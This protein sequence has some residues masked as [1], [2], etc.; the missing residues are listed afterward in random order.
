MDVQFLSLRTQCPR[1]YA[2]PVQFLEC[3]ALGS[4]GTS[5]DAQDH[6]LGDPRSLALGPG[7]IGSSVIPP[8]RT[9]TRGNGASMARRSP[10]MPMTR[11]GGSTQMGGVSS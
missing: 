5:I 10:T 9:P 7:A 2:Q 11:P 4:N 3:V 1:S 6:R 8:T